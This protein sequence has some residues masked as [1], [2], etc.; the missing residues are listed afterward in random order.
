MSSSPTDP[1]IGRLI[2][3]RYEVR[4]RVARGGMAT[5][6]R[7][8]D[9][10][11]DR[12]VAVKVLYAH[13]AESED[14]ITRF[15]REARAAARLYHPNV[16]AVHDQGISED[17]F[18]L[19]M[20]FVEGED[21]RQLL[22]R[23]GSLTL[24]AALDV[25]RA[26]LDALAAAHRRDLIHRDIKPENV[27][28]A[29]D[30]TVKVADFGLAR[31]VSEATAA[32]TGTVLGTVAYLAP[33]LVTTG[34]ASP[35]ADVYAVGIVLFEM[36][37][38]HQPF[39]GEMPINVAL[40]HVNSR[41][42]APSAELPW[43][44]TE[45][46]DLICELTARDPDERLQDGEQALLRL[47]AVRESLDPDLLERR[48]AHPA[49][50]GERA[51][52]GDTQ[53]LSTAGGSGT[54]ALPIG[55]L[56]ADAQPV[57]PRRIRPWHYLLLTLLIAALAGGWYFLL[58]PGAYLPVPPVSGL[59]AA[60][61]AAVLEE[62]G[63]RSTAEE[64]NHDTVP[65]GEVI[66]TLPG[67]GER[68]PRGGEVTLQV[69]LGIL[70]LTVPELSDTP[71]E[72]ALAALE[73]LGFATPT[74]AEAYDGTIAAGNVISVSPTAGEELPHTTVLAL[75]VSLGREPV[76]AP[77]VA[78]LPQAEAVAALEAAGL[79]PAVA[80]PETSM[81]VPAGSVIRQEPG[82]QEGQL[83]RG[84]TVTIVVSSGPPL[85][86]VPDVFGKSTREATRMLEEAGFEV[87]VEEILGG[88]FGTVRT[89]NPEAGT[90]APQGSTVVISI[91]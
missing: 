45:V 29:R 44:P 16:V 8:L 39:T 13:L 27:M 62:A 48:A 51:E 63:L 26:V 21:L 88:L 7:A 54:V 85:V 72:D 28:I 74:V 61:A 81:D 17:T 58:G 77:A 75:T 14:F 40:Q 18:Y 38:G 87:K 53:P 89:Q 79:A 43:L 36:L 2:D 6:Y 37:T 20:E 64:V 46:D 68:V 11:L 78:G 56:A 73:D 83:Y 52:E 50:D 15:R 60:R 41:V 5:V 82:P 42:P 67:P 71:R 35:A 69:S 59:D 33:E 70:M 23:E 86:E 3:G 4:E 80:E 84:D 66:T 12:E 76:S 57:R 19:T 49:V 10:R 1:M 24:G 90:L 55:G 34:Q 32:S 31:A 47:L 91:V 30:S 9:R 22:R 25:A 65:A